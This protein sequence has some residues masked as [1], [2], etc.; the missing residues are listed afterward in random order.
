V[1]VGDYPHHQ[2]R[3]S[4]QQPQIDPHLVKAIENGVKLDRL[5]GDFTDLKNKTEVTY[6]VTMALQEHKTIERTDT[7]WVAMG[8]IRFTMRVILGLIVLIPVL[9]G[10]L[11]FT[12][13]VYGWP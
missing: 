1:A 5:I 13:N 4:D 10:L 3:A 9:V 11:T 6:Q 8:E 2:R 12:H 7:L